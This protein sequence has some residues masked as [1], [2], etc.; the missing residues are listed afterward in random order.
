MAE[1]CAVRTTAAIKNA[2]GIKAIWYPA[3]NSA[4]LA[5]MPVCWSVPPKAPPAAVIKII[6]PPLIK[7]VCTN[8]VRLCPLSFLFFAMTPRAAT[9]PKMMA[10]F[11][12]PK[13]L[14]TA[15]N[16]L[17]KLPASTELA[18]FKKFEIAVSKQM[19]T[20]GIMTGNKET[21][22]PGKF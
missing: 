14:T 1:P 21:P 6:P 3:V 9:P 11:L 5:L 13:N 2:I 10:I 19:S 18:P 7:A 12:S 22:N 20:K 17:N 4:I 8:G 15:A 16:W